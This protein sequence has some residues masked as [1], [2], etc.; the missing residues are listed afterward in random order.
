MVASFSERLKCLNGSANYSVNQAFCDWS[1]M[2]ILQVKRREDRLDDTYKNF[3][4]IALRIR[5]HVLK[6][7]GNWN[8]IDLTAQDLIKH[9]EPLKDENG[10]AT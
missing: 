7:F 2:K 8:L 1:E 3:E 6:R 10:Y 4:N 9:W 5:K